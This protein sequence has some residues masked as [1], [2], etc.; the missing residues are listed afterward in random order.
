MV[1]VLRGRDRSRQTL[2]TRER[3]LLAE[4][5]SQGS[6]QEQEGKEAFQHRQILIETDQPAADQFVIKSREVTA[7]LNQARWV[8]QIPM[9]S[10]ALGGPDARR[11]GNIS[12]DPARS[13][14]SSR[15]ARQR[16][17]C[18]LC[19]NDLRRT[20][21]ITIAFLSEKEA[22]HEGRPPMSYMQSRLA[23]NA[24]AP[25][26]PPEIKGRWG[27]LRSL[28]PGSRSRVRR[29]R[30]SVPIADVPGEA[31]LRAQGGDGVAYREV[32]RWSSQWLRVFFE[33]HGPELSSWEV[34]AAVKE[35]IAAIHAKRH[36][37]DSRCPYVEWLGAVARYK[38]ASL[39]CSLRA[40]GPADAT[41]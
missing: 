12:P 31:M 7:A 32:L 25:A 15:Q 17:Y 13:A 36:T 4:Q 24:P 29:D 28:L 1:H 37:F 5:A 11:H 41:Y 22:V 3:R 38:S 26:G 20:T 27:G 35:T 6:K 40:G 33:Y 19:S 39:L 30:R 34:D 8:R 10:S 21:I 9:V 23:M 2:T 14:A 16:R 18:D